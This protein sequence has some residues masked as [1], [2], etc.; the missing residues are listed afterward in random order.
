MVSSDV[1]AVLSSTRVRLSRLMVTLRPPLVMMTLLPPV[2]DRVVMV[3]QAQARVNSVS[4]MDWVVSVS[5]SVITPSCWVTSRS[6][7]PQGRGETS[8]SPE[9]PIRYRERR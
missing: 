8:S 5:A 2:M 3:R 6:R 4:V 7:V 9:G 1:E